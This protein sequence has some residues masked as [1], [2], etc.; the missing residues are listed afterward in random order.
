[1]SLKPS[2]C[3]TKAQSSSSRSN[4]PMKSEHISVGIDKPIQLVTMRRRVNASCAAVLNP[5]DKLIEGHLVPD[6]QRFRAL[7]K[8]H[9][10]V[11]W[12]AHKSELEVGLELFA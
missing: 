1:F 9:H 6:L 5:I 12:V 4:F 10:A 3:A 11:P 7:I 2:F 8:R